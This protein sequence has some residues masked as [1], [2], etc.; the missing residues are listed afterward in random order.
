MLR[1]EEVSGNQAQRLLRL[2]LRN[3]FAASHACEAQAGRAIA[4]DKKC[5]VYAKQSNQPHFATDRDRFCSMI[6]FPRR[7]YSPRI[8][9]MGVR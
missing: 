4:A 5:P 7:P 6:L 1:A 8:H 9:A 3:W 2:A